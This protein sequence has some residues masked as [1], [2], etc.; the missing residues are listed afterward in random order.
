MR[1]KTAATST[2]KDEDRIKNKL[3]ILENMERKID[4]DILDF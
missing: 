3:R 1:P 2:K 4:E